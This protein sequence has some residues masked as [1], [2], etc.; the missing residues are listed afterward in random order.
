MYITRHIARCLKA[1]DDTDLHLQ[2]GGF[3]FDIEASMGDAVPDRVVVKGR[4]KR[5]ISFWRDASDAIL[6]I[7]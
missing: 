5:C 3:P 6:G 2:L 1:H 7:I 4:L